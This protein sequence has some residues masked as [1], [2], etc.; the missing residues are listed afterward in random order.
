MSASIA[1]AL[2]APPTGRVNGRAGMLANRLMESMKDGNSLT[3]PEPWSLLEEVLGIVAAAEK[4]IAEQ[5]N[6]IET[7]ESMVMTDPLTNLE[8]R[9]GF[10]THLDRVLAAAQRHDDTG[11][12]VYIDIDNFKM[13]NDE[14]GHDAGDAVLMRVADILRK[15]TRTSDVVARIGGDE[16]A[17]LLTHT[18]AAEG[19]YR[20]RRLSS[21][22]TQ[23]EVRYRDLRLPLHASFGTAPYG[24]K[25]DK[26]SLLRRAD[27]EMYKEKRSKD[28]PRVVAA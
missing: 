7:L 4:R 18:G 28:R 22:L 11:V 1:V 27:A 13:T 17:V 5:R 20:A 21:L 6:R 26:A 12:L 8:N 25:T 23:A 16:F 19:L 24:P 2:N 3:D 14:H 10:E 9:R 15:N